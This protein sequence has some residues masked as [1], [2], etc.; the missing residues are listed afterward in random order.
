MLILDLMTE[1]PCSLSVLDTLT[2]REEGFG[3]DQELA[4]KASH[5]ARAVAE[6]PIRYDRRGYAGGKKLGAKDAARIAVCIARYGIP[7]ALAS[8]RR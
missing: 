2:F 3:L 4:I 6:V 8:R 7:E 1:V 5:A